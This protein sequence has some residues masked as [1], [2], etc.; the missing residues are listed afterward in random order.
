MRHFAIYSFLLLILASG[1]QGGHRQ[2]DTPDGTQAGNAP[3]DTVIVADS[4]IYGVSD[5]FGMSTF[6]LI[7][8]KGDTLNVCRTAEDGT[9]G[10][11]FGDLTEGDRYAMT[12]RDNNEA[13][14]VLINLT[15]LERHLKNYKITNGQLFIDGKA[16]QI[17]SLSDK[18]LKL[19]E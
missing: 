11:V 14:G 3:Q 6:T 17:A 19:K 12:T 13:I 18:E 16:V 15:Q 4:T 5:E 9:D 1:C 7:S 8:D 10:A 2:S